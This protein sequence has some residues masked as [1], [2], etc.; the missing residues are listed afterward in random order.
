MTRLVRAEL[1]TSTV[2]DKARLCI[3]HCFSFHSLLAVDIEQYNLALG[4]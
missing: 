4:V 3:G 1:G 2:I